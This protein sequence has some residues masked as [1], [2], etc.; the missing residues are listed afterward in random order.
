[1]FDI[2]LLI[3][4]VK[5]EF[6]IFSIFCFIQYLLENFRMIEN[7]EVKEKKKEETIEGH[8]LS[9]DINSLY[10][11]LILFFNLILNKSN[12]MQQIMN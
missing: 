11:F 3:T 7:F 2:L 6:N 8:S 12:F 5:I 9:L 10:R 1:M 4:I